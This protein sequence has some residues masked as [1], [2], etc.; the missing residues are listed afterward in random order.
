MATAILIWCVAGPSIGLLVGAV[1]A[2]GVRD[3]RD[4][5]LSGRGS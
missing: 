4:Q 2:A 3:R 5:P 1:L